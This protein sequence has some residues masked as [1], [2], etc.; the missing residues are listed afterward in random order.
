MVKLLERAGFLTQGLWSG[1]DGRTCLHVDY[2]LGTKC[3]SRCYLTGLGYK[4]Q[5]SRVS[6]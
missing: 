6:G 1:S 5:G 2:L 3:L 4:D